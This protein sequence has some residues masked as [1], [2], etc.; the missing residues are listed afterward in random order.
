[1]KDVFAVEEELSRLVADSLRQTSGAF[2]F[3]PSI[4]HPERGSL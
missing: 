4:S 2:G 3:R 1:M